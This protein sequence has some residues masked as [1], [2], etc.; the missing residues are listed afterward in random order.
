MLSMTTS[1][2]RITGMT[3][4]PYHHG[5]LR[6][7]LLAEAE[8]TLREQ[9]V[10]QLSLRDLAREAGAP[11]TCPAGPRPG[12]PPSAPPLHAATSPTGRRC[13]A[14]WPQPGSPG[15]PTRWPRPSRPRVRTSRPGCGPLARP[16]YG[17]RPRTR[18]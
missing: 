1:T 12:R 17:S 9:G 13:W 11:G 8:R 16:T 14:R 10:E 18:P 5:H 3:D 4:R 2:A 6:D 7:T 15:W